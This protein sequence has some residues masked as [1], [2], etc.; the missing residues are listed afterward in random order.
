MVSRDDRREKILS[1]LID[2]YTIVYVYQNSSN[3]LP[4]K[5]EFTVSYASVNLTCKMSIFFRDPP[6]V[7]WLGFR[8]STVGGMGSLVRELRSGMLHGTVK[9]KN[10]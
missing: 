7:Q 3:Y 9:K 2:G 5:S 8:T 1:L 10:Y 6:A 4:Q